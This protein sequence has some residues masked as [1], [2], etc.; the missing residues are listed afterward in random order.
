MLN[1]P[2][3]TIIA[4]TYNGKVLSVLVVIGKEK[5]GNLTK[6]YDLFGDGKETFR[7]LY[8]DSYR[9]ATKKDIEFMLSDLIYWNKFD[10]YRE[11]FNADMKGF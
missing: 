11:K 6:C 4:N 3:N 10:F 8:K 9:V 1:V 2:K 5:T 7:G